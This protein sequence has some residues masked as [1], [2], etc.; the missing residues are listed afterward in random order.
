MLT[1]TFTCPRYSLLTLISFIEDYI[2]TYCSCYDEYKGE[3]TTALSCGH[4]F[5]NDCWKVLYSVYYCLESI[6]MWQTYVTMKIKD[7]EST[8]VKCMGSKCNNLFDESLIARYPKSVFLNMETNSF[9]PSFVDSTTLTKYNRFLVESYI[10]DSTRKKWCPSV[11]HC[12]NASML[13]LIYYNY[14]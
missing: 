14:Y 13:F 12:G 6:E 7:G 9:I 2:K 3:E 5:C 4:R 11:P 8:H 1:S 10:V